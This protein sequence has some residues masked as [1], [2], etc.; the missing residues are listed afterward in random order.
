MKPSFEV[1]KFPPMVK[2]HNRLHTTAI[3][4]EI[5]AIVDS[6]IVYKQLGNSC[7]SVEV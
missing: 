1:I 3:N 4:S 7:T 6:T 2:P 5:I